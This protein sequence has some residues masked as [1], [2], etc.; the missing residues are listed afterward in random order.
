MGQVTRDPSS[1]A[2]VTTKGL[3][4]GAFI[5]FI[6]AQFFPGM[7][8][9]T[10]GTVT[11]MGITVGGAVGKQIRNHVHTYDVGGDREGLNGNSILV[12]FLRVLAD[13]FI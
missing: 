5:T 1:V 11:T 4:L 2:K 9:I 13:I 12:S 8:A 7:D 3:G 10:Q 6:I